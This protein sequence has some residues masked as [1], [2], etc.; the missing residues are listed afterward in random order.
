MTIDPRLAVL[1]SVEPDAWIFPRRYGSGLSF[2]KPVEPA[3]CGD[4][5]PW[6]CVPLYLRPKVESLLTAQRDDIRKQVLLEAAD[7]YLKNDDDQLMRE[8]V[9]DWLRR[10]AESTKG[11][12]SE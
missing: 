9:A 6:V 4:G 12:K 11:E 10:M 1:D 7:E 5:G 2:V 8:Y 3:E